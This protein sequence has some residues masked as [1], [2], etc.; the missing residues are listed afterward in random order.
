MEHKNPYLETAI[1]VQG[2][3]SP[4]AFSRVTSSPSASRIRHSGMFRLE[5]KVSSSMSLVRPTFCWR[6]CSYGSSIYDSRLSFILNTCIYNSH[7]RCSVLL[8][9]WYRYYI[10]DRLICS[11]RSFS[12]F[13]C[14]PVL[15]SVYGVYFMSSYHR[16]LLKLEY[17]YF[18]GKRMLW[19]LPFYR[20]SIVFFLIIL[21]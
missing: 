12:G 18:Q 2:S 8:P 6:V 21:T 16:Y 15:L 13:P 11:Q 10:H 1:T 14:R 20:I 19:L 9:R 17:Y 4:E 7:F 3:L 5:G